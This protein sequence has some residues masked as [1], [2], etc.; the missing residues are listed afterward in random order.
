MYSGEIS[1]PRELQ[2]MQ[3]DVEQLRRHQR[4]VENRELELMEAREPLDATLAELDGQRAVLGGEL[5]RIRAGARRRRGARSTPRCARNARRATRSPPASTRA[6]VDDYERSPCP[7][8]GRRRGPAGRHHLPGLP[9]VRSRPP[10][11]SSIK[12]SAGDRSRVLRQLR[13]DPGPVMLDAVLIYFDGG[14]RGNPGP[15]GDRRGRARPVDH[16]PARAWPRSAS[17]S[18]RPPTT[19]PS[20]GRSSPGCEAAQRVPARASS[21]SAATP[22]W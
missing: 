16:A 4:G 14:A 8:A 11:R 19:S 7:G 10:R 22:S 13:R 20:T 12:K 18:A 3:A 1:S 15:G 2:A 6:L 17:A 9:P 21:A 5:E